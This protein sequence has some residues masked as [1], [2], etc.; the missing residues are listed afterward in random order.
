MTDAR[1]ALARWGAELRL[2]RT[3][4]LRWRVR[5]AALAALVIGVAATIVGPPRPLLVWN[6]SASAPIGLYLVGDPERAARDAM[7]V[8]WPP[9][10]VRPLAARRRYIPL[11][12]PLVKRVA[13]VAG[14]TVCADG[15]TIRINGQPVVQ[16][17]PRDGA[18]RA[19]PWWHG[20]VTLG[21]DAV[22]LLMTGSPASFDGRY[23]GPSR[24]GE[25]VGTAR[26][27]WS[28]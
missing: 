25:L 15:P 9:R 22:F 18:G 16:R 6:A 13:A 19:M 20:C 8:A 5:A 2:A 12:V 17:L 14:D 23:F 24:R 4:R 1:S 7:V 3:L 28:R 21:K 11:N 10:A 27:L 26:P